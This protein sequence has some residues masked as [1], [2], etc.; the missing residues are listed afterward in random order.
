MKMKQ[1]KKEVQKFNLKK[2]EVAK[3]KNLHLI[4][5]GGNDDPLDT[6]NNNNN[7]GK[8]DSSIECNK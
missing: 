2:F 3:L 4:I 6:N 8:K 5:G 7:K 1:E